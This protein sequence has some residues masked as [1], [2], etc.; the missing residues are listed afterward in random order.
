M[1]AAAPLRPAAG[2][3]DGGGP[4]PARRVP[5][6]PDAP[7]GETVGATPDPPATPRP[8]PARPRSVPDAG[9]AGGG[10]GGDGAEAS[11]ADRTAGTRL[12]PGV[13]SALATYV[14]L[15]VDPAVGRP[16]YVGRGRKDRCFRH[17]EAARSGGDGD[18]P[19]A[20]RALDRIRAVE[21]AGRTVRIEILR[22]GLTTKQAALVEAA[23]VDALGLAQV[24][25]AGTQRAPASA[26]VAGLAERAR[27]K[28]AHRIVLLR[29]GG[30]GTDTSYESVRHGWQI[31]RR[32]TDPASH[33]A[34][35]W[36]AVVVGD[37][38]EAVYRI[39]AWEPTRPAGP[40][41]P[42][43]DRFSFRGDRDPALEARY[44]GRSVAGYL[45]PSGQNPVTYVWC[46]PHWVNSAQ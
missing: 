30:P 16:F 8:D 32:W 13:A 19:G 46:G 35:G 24:T 21:A 27:I 26:V 14:Y 41:P 23:T 44:T 15:L 43:T 40:R 18:P 28:R 3:A 9:L 33:R 31:G 39:E 20:F 5:A 10:A 29:P 38:V 45:G 7:A 2:A 22:H 34:P 1:D 17:V 12:P 37:L 25:K 4:R 6:L 42:V 36:A 11:S